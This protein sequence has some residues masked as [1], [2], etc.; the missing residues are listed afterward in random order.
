LDFPS[1]PFD[2]LSVNLAIP[3]L[4]QQEALVA[5]RRGE[6][7]IVDAPTGAGKTWIFELFIEQERPSGQAVY[8]VPTRA[9]ANDKLREWRQKGWEVGI[10]TGDIA[11]QTDAPILV[12][13]LETQLEPIL[14][15]TSNARL[16]VIDEYQMLADDNRGLHYETA[17]AMAPHG[18]QLLL[19]SGSVSNPED[20]ASWLGRLGRSATVVRT[21]HRP[22]PLEEM[23]R[24]SLPYQAPKSV[25][26]HFQRLASEVLMADLGPLLIFAPQRNK[27]ENIARKIAGALPPPK[28]PLKLSDAQRHAC[29]KE[30]SRLLEARV[31]YHHSGLAYPARGGVVEPLAKAGQLR[32]IVATTGLAAGINFSV[33]S[34]S[35]ASTGYRDGEMERVLSPDELLQM[36]G[37]AGRRGLDDAGYVITTERSPRL[38]DAASLRLQRGNTVDW[39]TLLRTMAGAPENPAGAAR[40]LCENLFSDQRIQLGLTGRTTKIDPESEDT[41]PTEI[42]ALPGIG[43]VAHQFRDSRGEW[44]KATP[45]QI[46]D[47]TLADAVFPHSSGKHRPALQSAGAIEPRCPELGR[48][49]KLD[50]QQLGWIYGRERAIANAIPKQ[51]A[52]FR[53]NKATSKLMR[54]RRDQ[55]YTLDDLESWATGHYRNLSGGA[56]FVG[57]E[58]R[59]DSLHARFDLS[60]C[61]VSVRSDD[62]GVQILDPEERTL[63][64]QPETSLGEDMEAVPGTAAYA[65]RKL[66]LIDSDAVPTMRG[67]VFSFFSGGEGLAVAAAIEDQNYPVDEIVSHLANLRGSPRFEEATGGSEHLAVA[68][69]AI[70]GPIDHG[71]YLRIGLP[72]GYGDGAAEVLESHLDG[73]PIHPEPTDGI[74]A[75][76]PGDVERVHSEWLS[77]LRHIANAPNLEWSR[78]TDLQQACQKR[79]RGLGENRRPTTDLP[80]IAAAQLETKANHKVYFRR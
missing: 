60:A 51:D 46:S 13:T 78:W 71:G 22:V 62:H 5:L 9:L 52:S 58:Q 48:I 73:A 38:I 74:S 67:R 29:G 75:W 24:N 6:D 10:A 12:A 17:I 69:R 44:Q 45:D 15:G 1:S 28:N 70:Y 30:L 7:V 39:P 43:P 41:S 68:C 57:L 14:T 47:A 8:T 19:L 63:A 64:I 4:W 54:S 11:E 79:L 26:G 27:A 36:F 18:T 2:S 76:G 31:A 3:D 40:L 55:T 49:C 34:I 50:H 61:P 56:Q 16:F 72:L 53:P 65:W 25:T 77:L 23:W 59:G 35:I 37:R 42:E 21:D 20:V 80:A 33:R 66:G 32:V